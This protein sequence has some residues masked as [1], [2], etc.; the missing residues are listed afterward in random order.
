MKFVRVLKLAKIS[1]HYSQFPFI[2]FDLHHIAQP[3]F[4]NSA[5][6]FGQIKRGGMPAPV[7]I[8]DCFFPV[9][10]MREQSSVFSV[11]TEGDAEEA[12]FTMVLSPEMT[13]GPHKRAPFIRLFFIEA[14]NWTYSV[15]YIC[16]I[17]FH[18]C[19]AKNFAACFP[20]A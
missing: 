16:Q 12:G 14:I 5:L 7:K 10:R 9:S 20:A 15:K 19:N 11:E 3:E 2:S 17:L 8:H 6:Q 4:Y 18:E 13:P 1:Y